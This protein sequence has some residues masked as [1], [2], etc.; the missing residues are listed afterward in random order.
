MSQILADGRGRFKFCTPVQCGSQAS[1]GAAGGRCHQSINTTITSRPDG[2]TQPSKHGAR[3]LNSVESKK[4]LA[5]LPVVRIDSSTF[6]F[7]NDPLKTIQS[8]QSNSPPL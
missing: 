5:N 3:G 4:Q 1:R 7:E 8:S 2:L 6:W